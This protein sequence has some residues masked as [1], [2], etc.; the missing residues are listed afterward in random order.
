MPPPWPVHRIERYFAILFPPTIP[1]WTPPA[2]LGSIKEVATGSGTV[3]DPSL[4]AH[5]LL[6]SKARPHIPA[7]P[8]I[9]PLTLCRIHIRR[10]SHIYRH[11]RT[12]S[13]RKSGVAIHMPHHWLPTLSLR[14]YFTSVSPR[15]VNPLTHLVDIPKLRWRVLRSPIE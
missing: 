13:H 8:K 10:Q 12:A 6:R 2:S 4:L 3:L 15:R 11:R 1:H 9:R 14:S 7:L 5:L